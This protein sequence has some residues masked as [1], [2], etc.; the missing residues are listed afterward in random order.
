MHIEL[1][2]IVIL[3]QFIKQRWAYFSSLMKWKITQITVI[4]A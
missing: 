4:Y 2:I 3:D 1:P